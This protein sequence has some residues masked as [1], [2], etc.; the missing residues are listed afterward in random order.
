MSEP[1]T[2]GDLADAIGW[3]KWQH[4]PLADLAKALEPHLTGM[5]GGVRMAKILG[6]E[7][8]AKEDPI[9]PADW[10][11]GDVVSVPPRAERVRI[12]YTRGCHLCVEHSDG[13]L[14]VWPK[15]MVLRDPP[16]ARPAL[17][18][19]T[20]VRTLGGVGEVLSVEGASIRVSEGGRVLRY[21]RPEL[22]VVALPPKGGE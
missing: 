9:P 13:H 8:D 5:A 3:N 2:L 10:Q 6:D 18:P 16:A 15:G 7:G 1:K 4:L 22:K 12:V 19:G 11:V 14:T 17:E 20:V 21:G